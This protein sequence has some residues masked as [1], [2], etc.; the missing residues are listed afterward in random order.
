MKKICEICD[1]C[2]HWEQSE[3]KSEGNCKKLNCFK[4]FNDTCGYWE[5]KLNFN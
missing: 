2:K 4:Y 5:D 1:T 3:K